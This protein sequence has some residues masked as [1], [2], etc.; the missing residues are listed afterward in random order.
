[1]FC[2]V[3]KLTKNFRSHNSILKF[4]SEKFYHGDLQCCGETKVT[5]FYLNS[6]HIV[7]KNFPIVFHSVSGKDDQEA[8]SPSFFNIDE[9]TLV[10]QLVQKLRSDRKLHISQSSFAELV[11]LLNV[12]L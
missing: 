9:V 1:M 12:V 7:S 4:P 3:V 8:S 5:N 2:R 11:T 6:P 10:K